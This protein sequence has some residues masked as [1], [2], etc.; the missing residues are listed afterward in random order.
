MLIGGKLCT[1][2]VGGIAL[3]RVI[4]EYDGVVSGFSNRKSYDMM[5]KASTAL[6]HSVLRNI[7]QTE[8]K[9]AKYFVGPSRI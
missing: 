2:Y 9:E 7:V 4:V 1:W 6:P 5:P 3:S 8:T